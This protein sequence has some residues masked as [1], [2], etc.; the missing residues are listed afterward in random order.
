MLSACSITEAMWPN[1]L[2]TW[3]ASCTVPIRAAGSRR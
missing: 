1:V 3:G 2:A